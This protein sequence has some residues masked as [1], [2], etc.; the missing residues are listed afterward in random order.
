VRPVHRLV[1]AVGVLVLASRSIQAADPAYKFQPIVKLGDTV[2]D[3]KLREGGYF[4]V[5]SI[6]D[7]GQIAFLAQDSAGGDMLFQYSENDGQFIPIVV[8]GRDAPGGKWPRGVG[9]NS[10]V[11]TNEQGDLVFGTLS[12]P[13][14]TYRWS[15]QSGQVSIVAAKGMP[16]VN[17]LTF[18]TGG[19]DAM[20]AI[21]D[22]GEVVFQAT[23]KDASGSTLRAVFFLDRNGKLALVA[24]SGQ[25]VPGVGTIQV[26]AGSY[27]GNVLTINNGGVIGFQARRPGDKSDSV[28]VWENGTIT[29][30]ALAGADAPGGGKF[31]ILIGPIV[32]NKNRNLVLFGCLDAS[33][34]RW[35][36]YGLVG[37]HLVT[38]CVPGQE[39]PG[40]GKYLGG[41][42]TS[43]NISGENAFR[44]QLEG[45][46]VGVYRYGAGG[47]LSL[48]TKASE[49]NAQVV[50]PNSAGIAINSKG[51]VV[52]PVRFTGDK[53]DTLILLKPISP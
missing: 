24:L 52:L 50:L 32:N 27:G 46:D 30:V 31:A 53:V 34:P 4:W 9:I 16:A 3:L 25:T 37:G 1:L 44:V 18:A 40:G 19:D 43:V 14:N 11:Q 13:I 22:A 10:P 29:P 7:S 36:V 38:I 2:G 5:G 48:I 41:A 17:D 21:N 45:G 23:V 33:T 12:S 47:N 15:R 35:G 8:G 26:R 6:N 39:M 49:L 20:A 28:F 42:G 51:E